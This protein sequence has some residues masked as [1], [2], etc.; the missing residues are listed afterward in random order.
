ML[1]SFILIVKT[2]KQTNNI[3]ASKYTDELLLTVRRSGL[4]R[5]ISFK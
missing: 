2:K 4:D 5:V 3:K 1:S